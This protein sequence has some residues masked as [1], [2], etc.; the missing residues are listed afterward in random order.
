MENLT[1]LVSF[2]NAIEYVG[3]ALLAFGIVRS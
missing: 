3:L 1:H 2:V